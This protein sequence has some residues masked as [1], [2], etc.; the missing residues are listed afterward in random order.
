[1]K[2]LNLKLGLLAATA[3]LSLAAC[4]GEESV[5]PTK[6]MEQA[7]SVAES[8]SGDGD[9]AIWK[10]SDDDTDV[11]FFGTVH[12][13]PS[14]INWRSSKL[15]SI[16]ADMDTLYM[17]ADVTSPE[18]Q[19]QAQ[20]LI[21]TQAMYTDGR[22]LSD[23]LGDDKDIVAKAAEKAGLPFAG[24]EQMKPWFAGINLQMM[25]LLK[26]GY[27]PMSGVEMVLSK[28]AKGKNFAYFETMEEQLEML[29]GG[30]EAEQIEGL[31]FAA[32]TMDI[33]KR[34]IDTIVSEWADGD[35]PGM[36][37]IVANPDAI[38][39]QKAYDRLLTQRNANWIPQIEAILD[40]PGVKLVAVGG[41]HLVGP[42]S[43][44]AMLEG[45]GHTIEV[46]Q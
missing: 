26:D 18:A 24:I 43:V 10:L 42:D 4:S 8:T 46:V 45:K 15:D 23:A 30:T 37:A 20:S 7:I 33:G 5:S 32:E 21:A 17:E 19:R 1:M 29:G 25:L 27:N 34:T 14:G 38:G 16:I 41:A 39:G 40:D 28:E 11:Y 13:L 44:I 31:V 3:L 35:V 22:T 6:Q 12:V 36:A 9:P 2:N